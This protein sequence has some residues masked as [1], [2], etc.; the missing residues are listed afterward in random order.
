MFHFDKK[1]YFCKIILKSVKKMKKFLF[2]V[3]AIVSITLLSV[4][5]N[6]LKKYQ[7]KNYEYFLSNPQ[8]NIFRKDY[9]TNLI[10]YDFFKLIH[11]RKPIDLINKKHICLFKHEIFNANKIWNAFNQ[12]QLETTFNETCGNFLLKTDHEEYYFHNWNFCSNKNNCIKIDF[13]VDGYFFSKQNKVVQQLKNNKL[14]IHDYYSFMK[15]QFNITDP[16]KIVFLSINPSGIGN[17]LF[18]YI[19]AEIFAEQ[20]KMQIISLQKR[21]IYDVFDIPYNGLSSYSHAET[22]YLI[23]N[24]N[25]DY[26]KKY[27]HI[28]SNPVSFLNIKGHEE[29]IKNL[30]KFKKELTGKSKEISLQM[31]NE[32]SVSIHI[33]RGD[34]AT[35]NYHLLSISYYQ[36]AIQYMKEKFKNP[37]FYVFSDDIQWAKENLKTDEKITFVDWTTSA[38]ED[39]H[40]MTKTKHNI[41]ANSSFSW[42]GAFLNPNKEKIVIIPE[43]GFYNEG[44]EHMKV[45]D[46]WIVIKE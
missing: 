40:L 45:D 6:K 30:L 21:K 29:K 36:N 35:L 32:N 12:T 43:T 18:Q 38:E 5:Y 10:I 14:V 25:F 34:F 46:N 3:F 24:R 16:E 22:K 1:Q 44:W 4:G 42:W 2:F 26:K 31:Q 19:C 9:L 20:H 11:R 33:R 28:V 23:A 15:K 17:Q 37:H 13:H 39:L 7:E 27:F 41:V 8:T